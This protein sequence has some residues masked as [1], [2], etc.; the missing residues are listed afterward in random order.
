MPQSKILLDT[1]TYIRL[2]KSIHP[3]L[4]A[5]FGNDD[6]CLY[7]LKELDK[8][9]S[10]NRRLRTSFSWMDEPEYVDNRS[11]R[12]TLSRKDKRNIEI[13]V[14]FLKQ[15]KIDNRL[16]VSN[17]DIQCLAYAHVLDIP[18]VTDDT[19]MLEVADTFG[20][21]YLKTLNLLRLMLDTGHIDL[22]K[23]QQIAAYWE[24]ISD[25]PAGFRQE[26]IETFGEKPP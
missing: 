8:E 12:L 22:K 21:K 9:F 3:L 26:Y 2:A 14:D 15:H 11:K 19:D 20:I 1:N 25:K 10:S 4:D 13:T 16:S 24:Y 23:I 6:Y 17:V 5:P 18:V 7:V